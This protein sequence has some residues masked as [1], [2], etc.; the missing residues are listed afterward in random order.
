MLLEARID[1]DTI[2]YI[3]AEAVGGFSKGGQIGGFLESETLDNVVRVATLVG[4]R[5][6]ETA[7]LT[8]SV[9]ATEGASTL[10]LAFAVKVDAGAVVSIA[11]TPDEGQFRVT[12]RWSPR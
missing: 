9:G 6:A 2:V 4:R 7:R 5:L 11:K 12:A 1:Q 10:D 8:G 3:D